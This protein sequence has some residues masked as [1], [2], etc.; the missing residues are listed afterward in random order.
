MVGCMKWNAPV[1]AK[2]ST[3]RDV[4]DRHDSQ[5]A[6]LWYASKKNLSAHISAQQE[7]RK[8]QAN[9]ADAQK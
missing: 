3:A 2:L 9:E 5:E 1:Q 7:T 4:C 6:S 8:K